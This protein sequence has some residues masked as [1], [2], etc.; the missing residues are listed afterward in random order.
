MATDD[1]P[2][3]DRAAP[4]R[5]AAR[6][7]TPRW[8]LVVALAGTAAAI[9]LRVH[10]TIAAG[11]LWRDEA[12]SASTA[13]VATLAEFWARQPLDSFPLLWQLVLRGWTL[14]WNGGDVAIRTLGA[15]IALALLPAL[16]W[17]SRAFGVVPLASLAFAG[18]A[19]TLVVWAG[20]QNRAYGLGVTLLA[21][22]VGA[23]W[24]MAAAPT[25]SRIALAGV[26]ALLAVHTT[27]HLP[28]ML[29]AL[30]GAAVVVGARR[31]AWS[32][33]F[34]ASGVGVLAAASLLLYAG[35]LAQ[36]RV[37]A[38]VVYATVTL[39]A[40]LR[41][42]VTSIAP[43]S[44][45][46]GWVFVV[47]A[48]AACGWGAAFAVRAAW[49]APRATGRGGPGTG[50]AVAFAATAAALALVGQ[51]VFLLSL[52]FLVQP[53][54][55]ATVVLV[56]AIAIDVVLQRGIPI[57]W[58]R[59]AIAAGIALVLV[60]TTVVA[61]GAT[62][63]RL[64]NLDLVA[65][66]LEA[67]VRPGDL[68]VV[69]PWHWGVSFD[70]YY[71]GA[72]PFM[73]VPDVADHSHHRFDQ[74]AEL[75][76]DSERIKPGFRRIYQTLEAGNRVFVVGRPVADVPEQFP[77]LPPPSDADPQ[78]WR[79]GYYTAVAGLQLAWV[80]QQSSPQATVVTP[81]SGGPVS[82]YEDASVTLYQKPR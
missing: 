52:R 2:G 32:V 20:F 40:V 24:R 4:P 29:A 60:A 59:D 11:P 8:L 35:V 33:V 22:L 66:D 21:L 64:S 82:D 42:F 3:V 31:R 78:S 15:L 54:Y 67:K 79:D 71:D 39:P 47:L 41:G 69:Y 45:F 81:P 10:A 53:W 36:T 50:D 56:V 18:V 68:V 26:L 14:A 72:A 23:V 76:L 9:A 80:L 6:A 75:M 77:V 51:L 44:P 17:T 48:V 49:S 55:Y 57:A 37:Y 25:P 30:L 7:R 46:V 28:V 27:Y 74:L 12:G 61:S 43:G 70:R 58:L 16:W 34:A 19:P 73:T 63:R 1:A 62:G 38:K 5:A 13:T 65:R